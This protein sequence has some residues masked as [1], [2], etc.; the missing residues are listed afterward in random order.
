MSSSIAGTT[1]KSAFA[2]LAISALALM[3]GCAS[4]PPDQFESSATAPQPLATQAPA[5]PPSALVSATRAASPGASLGAAAPPA[6]SA[7]QADLM[8][9]GEDAPAP[10]GFLKFCG[11]RPDQCGL[12]RSGDADALTK[13][14]IA[15]Y[16]WAV[17]FASPTKPSL[18]LAPASGEAQDNWGRPQASG[19]AFDWSTVFGPGVAATAPA[20][21]A[22]RDASAVVGLSAA[23][24]TAQAPAS[25]V[26]AFAGPP[27]VGSGATVT[28]SAW[29]SAVRPDPAPQS[30]VPARAQPLPA[31]DGLMAELRRVND[32]V[33]E[34]IRYVPDMRQ[35]GVDDFWTLP[36]DPGGSAAGDCKDYVLEKRRALID[37]GLPA[38]DLSIA[39]VRTRWGEDHAV[40]LVATDKGE[41]VLDS[42]SSTILQWRRAPYAWIERQAPGQQLAWVKIIEDRRH[43]DRLRQR[44][45]SGAGVASQP[46]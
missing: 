31:G 25:A 9:L 35:Y 24:Q 29:P 22:A 36:L 14:L 4:Q 10:L 27:G 40:L 43:V 46:T 19:R 13:T 5:A 42:L 8:T 15:R 44:I 26:A 37:Q 12:D 21:F 34:S 16:Y 3:A 41:L 11:R 28:S 7:A 2:G 38:D 39:V 33:N 20:G 18:S 30:D 17:A 32:R 23:A 45:T 1:R 6:D